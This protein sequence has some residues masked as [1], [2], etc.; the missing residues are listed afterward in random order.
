MN[1]N[2]DEKST[3]YLILNQMN[4]IIVKDEVKLQCTNIKIGTSLQ[5]TKYIHLYLSIL[6]NRAKMLFPQEII[7]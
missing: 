1:R 5:N 7:K 3:I 6:E 2:S 4:L